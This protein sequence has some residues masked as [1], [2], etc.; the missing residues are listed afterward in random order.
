M[1]LIVSGITGQVPLSALCLDLQAGP[2][3]LLKMSA[4][5]HGNLCV[6]L[7]R[8]HVGIS[9]DGSVQIQYEQG[10]SFHCYC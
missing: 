8:H 9:I 7:R 3:L 10:E 4:N 2:A 1:C 6:E 5:D